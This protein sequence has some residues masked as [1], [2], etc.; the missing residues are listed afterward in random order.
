MK[1]ICIYCKFSLNGGLNND[2]S[3]LKKYLKRCGKSKLVQTYLNQF[4]ITSKGKSRNDVVAS[5]VFDQNVAKQK[6]AHMIIMHEYPL[7]MVEHEGFREY[8]MALQPAFKSLRLNQLLARVV[9]WLVRIVVDYTIT[10]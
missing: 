4:K 1:A 9:E 5:Y 2:T 7:S 10:R 8:C 3:H 6:L